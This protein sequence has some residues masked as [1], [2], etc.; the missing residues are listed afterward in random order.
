MK[1][2]IRGVRI[3]QDAFESFLTPSPCHLGVYF[4]N[5]N[6]F[7][8]S[9]YY[10]TPVF[11]QNPLKNTFWTTLASGGNPAGIAAA[12]VPILVVGGWFDI[13]ILA[14]LRDFNTIYDLAPS[15]NKPKL[16]IGPWAHSH[17]G[18]S[19]QG[20]RSF[21]AAEYGDSLQIMDFYDYYLRNVTAQN[22]PTKY[23]TVRYFRIDEDI[24]LGAPSWPAPGTVM[25]P[26]YF[27]SDGSLSRT[28]P[29]ASSAYKE[30]V[31]RP[32]SPMITKFGRILNE[33][34]GFGLQG[35]GEIGEYLSRSDQVSYSTGV[36]TQPMRIDGNITLSVWVSIETIGVVDTDVHIRLI[37]SYANGSR[38]GLND[39]VRRLSLRNSYSTAEPLSPTALSGPY[40]L[41][42]FVYPTS[43]FI[44]AGDSLILLVG[45]S[46][47]DEF[48]VNYQDGSK[49]IDDSGA[50]P[51]NGT[52]R[53]WSDATHQSVINFPMVPTTT[54]QAPPTS[55]TVPASAPVV[56]APTA[57]PVPTVGPAPQQLPSP[58]QAP[59][60]STPKATASAS[61]SAASL[62]VALLGA[63]VAMQF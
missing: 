40:K 24:F 15:N 17:L 63:L 46:N 58:T 55:I 37:H 22:Y 27:G 25:T 60:S 56:A 42:V 47:N 51:L 61:T 32:L 29:S 3:L 6:A 16:L 49:H 5:R 44:P 8:Q 33:T 7:V 34:E 11:K 20:G 14:N 23:P 41:D 57:P 18:D 53:I 48:E 59:A 36:L 45:S 43:L 21:P 50:T 54:P 19:L 12:G 31:S 13:H 26:Y 39:G 2:A 35:A 30:Y 10:P 38:V 1:F 4:E 62:F 52:I 9:Y 28:A